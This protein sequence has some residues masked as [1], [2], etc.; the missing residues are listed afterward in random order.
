M[1][2]QLVSFDG[3]QNGESGGKLRFR[4]IV[5]VYLGKCRRRSAFLLLLLIAFFIGD[6]AIVRPRTATVTM[7][8]NYTQASDGL[9]P[10]STRFN[11]YEL[12]TEPVLQRVISYA[13]LEGLVT[14]DTLAEC[15]SVEATHK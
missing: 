11:M 10:N 3:S 5:S 15:I 12:K 8:L 1:T 7:S 13:G 2:N 14:T 9:T 6:L 4:K